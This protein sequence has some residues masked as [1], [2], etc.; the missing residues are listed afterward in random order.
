MKMWP[1]GQTFKIPELLHYSLNK[2]FLS[3]TCYVNMGV[4]RNYSLTSNIISVAIIHSNW[5]FSKNLEKLVC[6]KSIGFESVVCP[7]WKCDK[8]KY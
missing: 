2:T 3:L 5:V 8:I 1:V 6:P 4:H 7:H